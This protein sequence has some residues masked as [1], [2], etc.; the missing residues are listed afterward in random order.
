MTTEHVTPRWAVGQRASSARVAGH[1]VRTLLRTGAVCA[2]LLALAALP[3]R[4]AAQQ[5]SRA[6]S[7]A[8]LLAGARLLDSRGES[9]AADALYALLV[10]RFGDTAAAQA[11]RE[12]LRVPTA[13]RSTRSGRV[14][15][16]VWTT[17]YGLWLGVAVPAAL[18]ADGPEPYGVGLLL[19]GPAGFLTGLNLARS[20]DLTDG[21]A[22]AIT[23]GGT[24]GTWQGFGWAQ[25][26]DL[27][28]ETVCN[29]DVCFF[30]DSADEKFAAMIAGGVTG[31]AVGA[32]LS[33][34]NIPQGVATAVNFGA[35][36]GTWFSWAGAYL[37]D[38]ED[39]NLLTAT[40]LGGNAA[41]L[42]TALAAPRWNISRNRARLISIGGVIGGLSGL[43]VNLIAQP[44]SDKLFVS[45]PLVMSA[46]G[47]AI[48]AAATRDYDARPAGGGNDFDASLLRLENGTWSVATP[49][50]VPTL[51]PVE[52]A[53]R[54]AWRPALGV[55]LLRARF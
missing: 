13:S 31:I 54:T 24:W 30:E 38:L 39:D 25:V 3:T 19:G 18:S 4:A 9:E 40:L 14:E 49:M 33:R 10:E 41:L 46:A 45:I 28:E 29:G 53:G 43:G 7:A 21:Q 8:V 42:A 15:L 36:W 55:T 11:A 12:R 26:F 2:F 6:D 1:R 16:Q 20:R 35:L 37:A 51:L 5:V 47:L 22:R 48:S 32:L 23:L 34:K 44:S 27:G 17:L 50:P 52:H